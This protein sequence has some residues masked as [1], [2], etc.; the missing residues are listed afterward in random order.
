MLKGDGLLGCDRFWVP[1]WHADGEGAAD[2][3]IVDADDAV[4]CLDEAFG[5]RKSES[6]AANWLRTVGAPATSAW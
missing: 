3:F 4:V 6:T 2:P 5:D 1:P